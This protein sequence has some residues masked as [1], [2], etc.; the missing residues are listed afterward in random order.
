MLRPVAVALIAVSCVCAASRNAAAQD[1]A[2]PPA[3]F[4]R[5]TVPAATESRL[6][7]RVTPA[8][9]GSVLPALYVSLVGLQAYDGYSTSRGL[10]S[11]AFEANP[12]LGTLASHPAALWAVKGATAFVSIY[13]AERLWRE[14]HRGQAIVLMVL[15]NGLMAAVAAS[16]ASI[17]RAQR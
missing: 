1:S 4:V 2:D 7:G 17:I 14:H 3:L 13:L 8:D 16:N 11:G 12:L 5:M 15:S 6:P 10:K 9:R